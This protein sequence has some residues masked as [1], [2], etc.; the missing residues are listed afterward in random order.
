M[1]VVG[2]AERAGGA[3]GAALAGAAAETAAAAVA[4]EEAGGCWRE[5]SVA[6]VAT[7]ALLQPSAEEVLRESLELVPSLELLP[8][9]LSML[10]LVEVR[11]GSE[12]GVPPALP[13]DDEGAL[14][15][16]AVLRRLA[17]VSPVSPLPLSLLA[18]LPLLLARS[19][20]SSIPTP[21]SSGP[22]AMAAGSAAAP[23]AVAVAAELA[24][25]AD[26]VATDEDDK[27]GVGEAC[28]ATLRAGRP[29]EEDDDGEW[30]AAPAVSAR[31]GTADAK[32]AAAAAARARG[33]S[34]LG[35]ASGWASPALRLRVFLRFMRASETI[36]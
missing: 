34:G 30:R 36:S 12:L 6:P 10:P 32:E 9:V 11:T 22:V 23:A 18:L 24:A 26:E 17:P 16:R 7:L 35:A 19:A 27:A 29:S 33:S 1:L 5:P 28:R 15:P 14:P 3:G 13:L 20:P 21:S 4:G 25:G 2:A 8:E 31:G